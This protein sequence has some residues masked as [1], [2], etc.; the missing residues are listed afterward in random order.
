MKQSDFEKFCSMLDATCA[1][2]SRGNYTPNPTST[3]IFFNA[4]RS[5]QFDAVSAAFTAHCQDPQRGRFPPVPADILAQIDAAAGDD[6]R[7]GEEEA[8]AISIRADSEAATVVWTSEMAEAFGICR[9][10]L[11]T[12]DEVGARMAFRESYRRLVLQSRQRREPVRWS[13]T[14]GHDTAMRDEALTLAVESGRLPSAYLPAPKAPVA[15]LLELTQV[16]GIPADVKARL[17]DI[18]QQIAGRGDVESED[19]AAKR[20]TVD[21]KRA[22]EEAVKRY[23]GGGNDPV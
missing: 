19:A 14:L 12:G 13:P 21:A 4:L 22:A 20:H 16:R 17:L 6:G 1:M 10:V 23:Q 8:W 7:P 15:G 2:L 18:R 5:H 3:A 9:A 11:A